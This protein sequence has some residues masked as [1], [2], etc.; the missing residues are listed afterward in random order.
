MASP[1]PNLRRLC[2]A[3][4]RGSLESLKSSSSWR[5]LAA[6]RFAAARSYEST[7]CRVLPEMYGCVWRRR[8]G[9]QFGRVEKRAPRSARSSNRTISVPTRCRAVLPALPVMTR[10]DSGRSMTVTSEQ[11]GGEAQNPITVGSL[12]GIGEQCFEENGCF[13]SWPVFVPRLFP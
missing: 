1:N 11:R 10:Y 12:P 5:A 3:I 6:F 8:G 7:L 2:R 4:N 13:Q 9:N